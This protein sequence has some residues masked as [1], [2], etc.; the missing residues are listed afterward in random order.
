[1]ADFQDPKISQNQTFV[2]SNKTHW[3]SKRNVNTSDIAQA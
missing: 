3:V 1:M 2:K